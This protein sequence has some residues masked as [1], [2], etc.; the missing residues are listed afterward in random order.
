MPRSR[1]GIWPGGD[2]KDLVDRLVR[3]QCGEK[4]LSKEKAK[5][6]QEDLDMQREKKFVIEKILKHR[7]GKSGRNEFLVRWAPV[8][9]YGGRK[10]RSDD[11]WEPRSNFPPDS[12][13]L[14]RWPDSQQPRPECQ[15][16]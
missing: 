11:T 13:L 4:L 10:Q 12:K 1:H 9:S 5:I 6:S 8:V 16:L 3:Y 2:K 7:I 15:R 14:K